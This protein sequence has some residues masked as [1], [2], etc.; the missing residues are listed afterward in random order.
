[1]FGLIV[2]A[3]NLGRH[4]AAS[5]LAEGHGM[6]IVEKRREVF[7]TLPPDL[8]KHAVQGD[9]CDPKVLERAGVRR[10]DIVVA[11]AN[12]DEDNLVACFLARRE[13]GVARTIARVNHPNN[14]WMFGKDMGVDVAISQAH[15]LSQLI[16]AE[17]EV[18]ELIPLLR[19]EEGE[20]SLLEETIAPDSEAAGLP[21]GA[22]KLPPGAVPV[23]LLRGPK[24]VVPTP[25]VVVEPGDRLVALASAAAG[26]QATG[27]T[28]KGPAAAPT[29]PAGGTPRPAR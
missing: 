21:V 18:G 3:G 5:L 24:I 29:L 6:S 10:A 11:V 27:A 7:A 25:D 14:A 26:A 2:G 22:L 13:Y 20:V 15:I 9:A 4:V 12:E 17:I 8:V 23:A 19:L 16:L 1:M 28:P